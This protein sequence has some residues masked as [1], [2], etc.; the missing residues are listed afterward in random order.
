MSSTNKI[1]SFELG[2]VVAMLAILSMHCQLFL[3]YLHYND[4]PWF[5]YIFNQATRFAV[6]LFFLISGYLIQP[7]LTSAPYE[8]LKSYSKPLI[9]VWLVWSILSLVMPFNLGVVMEHGYIAERTGYWSYLMSAPFNSLLEG[10]LVH[11][12]FIPAL[13]SA[14]AII[15]FLV[16]SKQSSLIIPIAVILYIYG[17]LAGSYQTIT[18]LE[19]PFFTR[20]GPFFATLMV[21]IGFVIRQK[22]IHWSSSKSLM[23]ALLGLFVHMG[24]AWYLHS[25]GQLFNA[26]DFLFG[27][28]VWATGC[29]FWLLSKPNL[30]NS[31]LVFALSKRVLSVY[32][33]HMLIIIIM[34]NVAGF[35]ELENGARDLT[36]WLGSVLLTG[37]FVLGLEKTPLKKVLFR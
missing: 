14:I 21:A 31:P 30:G 8:T 15:A 19:P 37:L 9:R 22:D 11:L 6:P 13:I 1:A 24:E 25:L 28:A 33:S 7:K 17:V 12:W 16:Q 27:T 10:G 20:N 35:Y 3:G 34:I 32:V 29:F 36:V 23:V 4:E 26:N 18:E 5:G 2:R